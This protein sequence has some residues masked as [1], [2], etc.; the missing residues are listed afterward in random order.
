[1]SLPNSMFHGCEE[2]LSFNE[3]LRILGSANCGLGNME[4][5]GSIAQHHAEWSCGRSFL[6]ISFDRDAIEIGAMEQESL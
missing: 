5:R 2:L 3:H 4:T 1:M 6:T